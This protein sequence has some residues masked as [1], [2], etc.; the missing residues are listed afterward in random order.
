MFQVTGLALVATAFVLTARRRMGG[1]GS[2]H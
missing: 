1:D 2:V